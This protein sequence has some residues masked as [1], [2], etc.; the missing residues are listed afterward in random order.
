MVLNQDDDLWMRQVWGGNV[1]DEFEIEQNSFILRINQFK[2]F[3]SKFMA[4]CEINV[5]RTV[6]YGM[7]ANFAFIF[8]YSCWCALL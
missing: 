2:S 1:K 7:E 4:K 5:P 3:K 6:S 8:N